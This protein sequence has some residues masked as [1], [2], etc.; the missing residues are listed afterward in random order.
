MGNNKKIEPIYQEIRS[1]IL[2]DIYREGQKLSEIRLSKEYDC[3]RTPIREILQRLENDGL[4][5][6]KPKSGTYVKNETRQDF[7]ELMQ[8]RAALESLAFSLAISNSQDKDI[9]R[10][11][12]LKKEM[13]TLVDNEPIE[14]MR[15]AQ[16][17][18][19]FHLQ[20][21]Q[22]SKNS[23]LIQLFG[24]LNLRSSH[25]FYTIM[26]KNLGI[27]TQKEHQSIIDYLKNKDPEGA[28]FIQTHLARKIHRYLGEET[29]TL[30]R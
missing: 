15:F 16:I 24:R 25:M 20:L 28:I 1:K 14:M 30:S 11:E 8:V 6:I 19:R 3:S 13:D 27:N 18:Y 5:I 22:A 17:H 9:H 29:Q 26:D 12:K 23:L 4:I 10:V 2:T 7:V 21:V